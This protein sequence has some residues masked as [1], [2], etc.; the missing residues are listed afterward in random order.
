M[1][2]KP[3][4]IPV[5]RERRPHTAG[6]AALAGLLSTCQ[7]NLRRREEGGVALRLLRAL[8]PRL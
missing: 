1:A 8:L 4:P 2:P 7:V 3:K 6:E 5:P